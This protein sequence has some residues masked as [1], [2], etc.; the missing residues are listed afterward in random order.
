MSESEKKTE[1][2]VTARPLAERSVFVL[3]QL[4]KLRR[5]TGPQ[6][7]MLC[8]LRGG[9]KNSKI[10]VYRLCKKHLIG[11][12]YLPIGRR[13][14]PLLK[15]TETGHRQA[16]T[17][18]GRAHDENYRD[19]VQVDF[20]AHLLM[21]NEL[22]L[23]IIA[24]GAK[25][26]TAVRHN[27]DCFDWFASN[28]GTSFSWEAPAEFKSERRERRLVPDIT[29][30]T[31]SAR[32]L[33]EIER[34]TKTQLVV[35][36]KV[37]NYSHLFS[38]LRSAQDKTGYASKYPDKK[39][40][41]VVFVFGDEQ[42]ALN[43]RAHFERRAKASTTFYIPA[44]RCGTVESIG[45]ELRRELFGRPAPP[46]P[47]NHEVLMKYADIV[48]RYATDSLAKLTA[49]QEL[50]GKQQ[51]VPMPELPKSLPEM[52]ALLQLIKQHQST[53]GAL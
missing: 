14:E 24:H 26:W 34:S 6:F 23:R 11:I 35:Q 28:D 53:G 10:P 51:P 49:I 7:A 21:G 52:H 40:P 45:D 20:L 18:M 9:P 1:A 36:Q 15:L 48:R 41:I 39:K 43:A 37:E 25:D 47:F 2:P 46:L 29:I 50:V 17:S 32:Y 19:Y 44:W 12:D 30:E 22:Y 33:V 31:A 16:A 3:Q 4:L 8:R 38:P 42:R 13:S 5:M 27:S